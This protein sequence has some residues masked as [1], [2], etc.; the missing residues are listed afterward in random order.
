MRQLSGERVLITGGGSGFGLA[1]ARLLHEAGNQ[2]LIAGRNADRL[3][4]ATDETPG[5][6][7]VQANVT[8][9]G[10]RARLLDAVHQQLG[11]LSVLVNNA[12][13]Q[14]PISLLARDPAATVAAIE[15]ELHADLRAPASLTV[16]AL[17]LLRESP[18]ATVAFITSTLAFA[19]KQSTPAY[20]A[21]KAG[22]S[23]FALSLRYQVR[24][25]APHIRSV[26]ITLPLVDTPMTAGRGT[27]KISATDAAAHTLRQLAAGRDDIRVGG[28][29]AFQLL[30][31]IAPRAAERITRDS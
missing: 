27:R 1:L 2:V 18:A 17:P 8:L 3:R 21:A 25:D 26:L 28:A 29:R 4:A 30:H 14:T 19:P 22:L 12:A 24:T 16:E 13:T 20:N 11:G 15:Q 5:L 31:R 7:A 9:P 6:R 23:T 10:E